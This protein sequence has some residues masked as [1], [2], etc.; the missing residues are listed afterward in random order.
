MVVTPMLAFRTRTRA[1]RCLLVLVLVAV[2]WIWSC[3]YR[4]MFEQPASVR[5]CVRGSSLLVADMH[6]VLALEQ[7]A[8]RELSRSGA[9]GSCGRARDFEVRLDALTVTPEGIVAGQAGPQARAIRATAR[10]SARVGTDDVGEVEEIGFVTSEV[11]S[12]VAPTN[13]LEV[14][15]ASDTRA[16]AARKAGQALARRLLRQPAPLGDP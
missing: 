11:V 13:T 12:S 2:P 6:A 3:G 4:P 15:T 9:L 7:G 16:A 8:R 14:Q 10:A 1:H 5:Y